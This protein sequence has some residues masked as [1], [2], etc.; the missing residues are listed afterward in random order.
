MADETP[1]TSDFDVMSQLSER[2]KGVGKEAKNLNLKF[3]R[4]LETQKQQAK[5]IS[6]APPAPTP[7]PTPGPAEMPSLQIGDLN[8]PINI[9]P[10][11]GIVDELPQ[12]PIL[13]DTPSEIKELPLPRPPE[14]PLASSEPILQPPQPQIIEKIIEQPSNILPAEQPL[15]QQT[16]QPI[17]NNIVNNFLESSES[18]STEPETPLTPEPRIPLT[19]EPP[20]TLSEPQ[21]IEKI[22][23]KPVPTDSNEEF[24]PDMMALKPVEPVP[25]VTSTEPSLPNIENVPPAQIPEIN[26]KVPEIK[27]PE[28]SMP[29][30]TTAATSTPIVAPEQS[31]LISPTAPEVVKETIKEIPVIT[32]QKNTPPPEPPPPFQAPFTATSNPE[33]EIPKVVAETNPQQTASPLTSSDESLL[34]IS[35]SIE[36]LTATMS[37]HNEK[38]NSSLNELK[39]V[40]AEILKL[41]PSL[42]SEGGAAPLNNNSG[43]RHTTLDNTN[44]IGNYRES[45]GLTSKGYVRNTVFPGNNSIS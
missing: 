16:L 35:K 17:N 7:E 42:K 25:P 32:E 6:P 33:P 36:M 37:Q 19:P 27:I 21:I 9:T 15:P 13:N 11:E 30:P 26:F 23:E 34:N 18:I 44:I 4:F 8:K 14:E 28:I 31:N 29:A 22:I 2:L 45:L 3:S 43:G 20:L 38:L 10:E 1:Q 41:L 5:A 40:A 39:N 12:Q 24:M